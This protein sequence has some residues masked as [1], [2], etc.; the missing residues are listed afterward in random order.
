MLRFRLLTVSAVAL[1][2]ALPSAA[3]AGTVRFDAATTSNL[4]TGSDDSESL[5]LRIDGLNTVFEATGA[6]LG[7]PGPCT[8]NGADRVD[9][10]TAMTTTVNALGA[11]DT[12]DASPLSGT[13]LIVD[14][15]LGGDYVTDGAG[16]DTIGGGPGNDVNI[17]GPGTD[18]FNGGDGDDT[19]DY[20]D[21][22]RR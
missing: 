16:N 3:Q 17:N 10:A 7:G 8:Q 18:V 9:C 6:V 11:D 19:V 12:I 14:A 13:S 21:A 2:L 4:Y 5:T 20:S 22:A 15:G 1:A